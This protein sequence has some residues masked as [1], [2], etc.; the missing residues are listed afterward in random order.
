MLAAIAVFWAVPGVEVSELWRKQTGRERL[1]VYLIAVVNFLL[2]IVIRY[3]LM[4][5]IVVDGG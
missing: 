1:L 4:D 2:T 3:R 5:D